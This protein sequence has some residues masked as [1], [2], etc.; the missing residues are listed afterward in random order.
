MNNTSQFI[1]LKII[2]ISFLAILFATIVRPLFVELPVIYTYAGLLNCA[3]CIVGYLLVKANPYPDMNSLIVVSLGFF[4]MAP[5]MVMSGGINSHFTFLIPLF[6]LVAAETGGIKQALI[7]TALLILYVVLLVVFNEDILSISNMHSSAEKVVATGFWLI[8]TIAMST[9]FGVEIQKRKNN[10]IQKLAQL[11]E[12]DPLTKV[13][14]RRGLNRYLQLEL[15]KVDA[16]NPLSVLLI[17]IDHF[18]KINDEFGHDVGDS[19]LIMLTQLLTNNVRHSDLVARMGG[20]EFLI[21][22]P[23]TTK[24]Q[25]N[26]LAQKLLQTISQT[27]LDTLN[28][29]MTVTVGVAELDYNAGSVDKLIKHADQALYEGKK[30]G[31]NQVVVYDESLP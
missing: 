27:N 21:A 29:A 6:P 3:L 9:Y 30:Q 11:A 8:M 5:I 7:T 31:R 17:D 23:D 12:R 13:L 20:E 4:V 26:K 10:Y 18:K 22:L 19:C 16:V 28:R 25:A 24:E 15:E 1:S 14:N 2:K